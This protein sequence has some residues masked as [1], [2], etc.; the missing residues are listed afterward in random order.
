GVQPCALPIFLHEQARA[1]L[2]R[3]DTE[4]VEDREELTALMGLWGAETA[5]RVAPG[6]PNLPRTDV[7]AEGLETL[8][9]GQRLDLAAARQRIQGIL[10]ARDLTRW[11]RFGSAGGLG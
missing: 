10:L 5:G 2:A 9:V 11:Y 1:D 8:A 6:P 3:A 4:V 7:A